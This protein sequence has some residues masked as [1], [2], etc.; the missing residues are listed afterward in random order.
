VNCCHIYNR[1][2][3]ATEVANNYNAIRGRF[4]G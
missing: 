1:V 4:G 2:L 3:S